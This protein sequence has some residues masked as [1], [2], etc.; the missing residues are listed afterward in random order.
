MLKEG[1]IVYGKVVRIVN[2]G[3]FVSVDDYIGLVH[4]SD[5][6]DNYVKSI[7]SFVRKG[8]TEKFKILSI[9]EENK[10]LKLSYKAIHKIRGVKWELPQFKIGFKTLKDNMDKFIQEKLNK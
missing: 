8:Q 7:S 2:Y 1:D 4:I 3:A 6:S 10:R 5:F 9:D